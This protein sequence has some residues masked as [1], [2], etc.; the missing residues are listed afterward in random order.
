MNTTPKIVV[1]RGDYFLVILNVDRQKV[2]HC[3]FTLLLKCLQRELDR[4]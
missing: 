2:A 3:V 1:T 4:G